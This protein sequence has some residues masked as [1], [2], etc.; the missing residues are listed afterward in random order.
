FTANDS[1]LIWAS[2]AGQ[3]DGISRCTPSSCN[4]STTF[5]A[6]NRVAPFA[7]KLDPT[8][9]LYWL[10]GAL[11]QGGVYS[12]YPPS[13]RPLGLAQTAAMPLSLAVASDTSPFFTSGTEGD[14]D[15]RVEWIFSADGI[16]NAMAKNRVV[17]RAITIDADDVYWVEPGTGSDGQ[18]LGC[19]LT[20]D[21]VCQA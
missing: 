19:K 8:G 9:Q 11:G 12:C 2:N 1:T 5:V 20:Y 13:C 21:T 7:L 6:S 4:S 14:T 15:G 3:F 16:R 18:V 17:P 10:E